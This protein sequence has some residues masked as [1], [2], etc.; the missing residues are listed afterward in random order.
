MRI[1]EARYGMKLN[2]HLDRVE[3]LHE[4]TVESDPAFWQLVQQGILL[5]LHEAG[6]INEIQLRQA[7]E[8]LPFNH[9]SSD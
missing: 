2:F 5:S 1:M 4:I 6:Q 9:D 7:E 3:N 8:N